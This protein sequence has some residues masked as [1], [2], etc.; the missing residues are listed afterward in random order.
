MKTRLILLCAA[1]SLLTLNGIAQTDTTSNEPIIIDGKR[2]KIVIYEKGKG[3]DSLSGNEEIRIITK[4]E[5]V[6]IKDEDDKKSNIPVQPKLVVTE[7]N[8]LELGLNNALSSNG[9]EMPTS[10]ALMEVD[11]ARSINFHWGFVQQGLNLHK[12]KLRL[13]YGLGIEFNNYRFTN[14][15]DL[16]KNSSPLEATVITD[17]DYAKNKLV[18][19]YLTV[20]LILNYKSKPNDEEH[21]F[22][23]SA[24]VQAGY[25]IGSHQKQKWYDGGKEKRKVRD[26]FNLSDYRFGYMVSFGYGNFN[27]YA[28]YYPTPMFQ[29]GDGQELNTAAAGLVLSGF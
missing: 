3:S 2:F 27:L 24:G 11:R 14:N 23:F 21:S 18:T 19:Q 17:R 5:D 22:N 25:L 20:P 4:D 29:D 28:K 10:F 8:V 6:V 7:W 12:G 1:F 16:V 9:F 13:V 15:I 26:D